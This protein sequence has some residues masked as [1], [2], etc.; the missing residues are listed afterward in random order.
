MEAVI[1]ALISGLCVAIPSI[2]AT[3]ASNKKNNELVLYRINELDQKVHEHNNLIDRMYK[4]E[5][6][7]TLLEENKKVG[8]K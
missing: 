4:V 6:R 2:I 8:E 3:V 5:N 1:T 7:V